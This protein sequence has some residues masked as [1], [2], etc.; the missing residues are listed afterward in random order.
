M[1]SRFVL[2]NLLFCGS[3]WELTFQVLNQFIFGWN[4]PK[5]G[6]MNSNRTHSMLVEKG[7]LWLWWLFST[8]MQTLF[9]NSLIWSSPDDT[10]LSFEDVS[11]AAIKK[12][13]LGILEINRVYYVLCSSSFTCSLLRLERCREREG[14]EERGEEIEEEREENGWDRPKNKERN[15]ANEYTQVCSVA[16][17]TCQLKP[18]HS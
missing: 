18:L 4:A 16:V 13:A 6:W 9:H 5:S 3:G 11:M 15:S 14:R 17:T 12:K 2:E 10:K 7:Y 1:S 8:G